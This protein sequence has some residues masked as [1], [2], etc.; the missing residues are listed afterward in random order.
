MLKRSFA[1]FH[2]QKELPE[3]RQLLKRKLNQP[4]KAI[5]YVNYPIMLFNIVVLG[6]SSVSSEYNLAVIIVF[7]YT[8]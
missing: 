4:S 7:S 2:A 5:E 3:M 8:F 1:E 6:Y